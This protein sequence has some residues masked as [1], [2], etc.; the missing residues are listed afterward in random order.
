MGIAV[1]D[2]GKVREATD[3]VELITKH[4]ALRRVG[5]RWQGLCPFHDEKTPSFSVNAEEGL[6]HCF[7][8]KRSGD[9][10][11]FVQEM[12]HL[13]FP[14][15]VALLADRAGI[16]ITFTS[17][18]EGR[19]RSRHAELSEIV[20][21]AVDF[22]H[23]RLLDMSD[24]GARP[25]REYL[26]SRGYG[27]EVARDYLLGWAPDDWDALVTSLDIAESDLVDSGLGFINRRGRRQ[28]FFRARVMFPIHDERGNAVGFGGRQ[29]P[30]GQPPKY[31]N[32]SGDAV[33][34]DK[35]RVLYGLSF[36]KAEITRSAEAIVC[37]G[38]TDAIG[39]AQA[40][41]P[42]AVATCGTALTEQHVKLLRRF[43]VERLVLAFD[44]DAAGQAA[45]SRVYEWEQEHG[46]D[47][48]VARFPDGRDPGE[49][50]QEDPGLL[51]AAVERAV[52]LMEFRLERV[53]AEADLDTPEQR[54]RTA[55]LATS[56]I[57]EH[58]SDLVRDQYLREVA[59]RCRV[60]PDQL[61]H[62]LAN[63][64]PPA[65]TRRRRERETT[66]VDRDGA[67]L[68]TEP[69]ATETHDAAVAVSRTEEEALRLFV[70]EPAALM[71]YL[72]GYM[73]SSPLH[74]RAVELLLE[75][76]DLHSSIGA[77]DPA[78]AELLSRASV[79]EPMSDPLDTVAML[80]DRASARV[81]ESLRRDAVGEYASDYVESIAWLKH[82]IEDL[83]E[84]TTRKKA[85]EQI[86]PWLDEHGSG[87]LDDG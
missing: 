57:A 39:F 53:F 64:L 67:P 21:R 38:Y 51:A 9:A 56:M 27:G 49:L 13:D 50:A 71:P 77:A 30:E 8:C 18:D 45:A 61:R 47:V 29:L 62:R 31:K 20:G 33:V 83:R 1:D 42:R 70:L 37:E 3:I 72:R 2:I 86:L 75:N 87:R 10:I 74:R 48:T 43:G 55:E 80:A 5:R 6:Y 32:T 76:G 66:Y 82:R 52:P 23:E 4:V 54:A 78:T 24:S 36:H 81:L 25:A 63:P 12:D 68:P 22:Y 35:S 11:T 41:L 44:A 60:S 73:F 34:Y 84:A 14:D 59:D 58:P 85:I 46:I 69:A 28:D 26:R 16:A 65:E 79:S 40:H 7:G 15:A 17:V 19:R